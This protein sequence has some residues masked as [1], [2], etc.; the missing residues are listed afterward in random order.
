MKSTLIFLHGGPG[1]SDYLKPYFTEL[2][3]K[4]D[5]IFYDQVRGP[6]V[7]LRE[8]MSELHSLVLKSRN[9]V[10]LIGHSWG[11]VLA[12]N[13]AS[14]YEEKLAGLVLMSTGLNALQWRDEFR[15]ELKNLGLE[16][17]SP[18]EIFLAPAEREIGK[19]LLVSVEQTFSEE[20][21][22]HIFSTYLNT[23]DLTKNLQRLQIPVLNIF[24]AND[25][26]FPLRVARS[27][28]KIK[29]DVIELELP[30]TGHF[31]F[32]L[33]E[34]RKKISKLIIENFAD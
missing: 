22:D 14:T 4:F 1:F 27:F 34:N 6:L 20:T 15:A 2:E 24:G 7:T 23:Y 19:L 17:A 9:K 8:Q 11:G 18:E 13:Y 3:T 28:R 32:L 29:K 12:T 33:I 10:V 30:N 25:V 31:P 21:F 26:R 5:C 16:N